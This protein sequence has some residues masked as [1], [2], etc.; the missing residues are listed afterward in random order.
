[1]TP[2]KLLVPTLR[3]FRKNLNSHRSGKKPI[4]ITELGWATSGHD[5]AISPFKA[6]EAHRRST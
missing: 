3:L 2:L 5:W 1:M 4:W 6:T